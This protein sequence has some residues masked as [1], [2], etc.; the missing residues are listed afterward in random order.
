MIADSEN[1]PPYIIFSDSSLIEMAK[2]LPL[3]TVDMR[4]ISGMGDFKLEKY[5]Q[6]FLKIIKTYC[7][8][9]DLSTKIHLK[10]PKREKKPITQIVRRDSTY[11]ES[12]QFFLEGKSIQEIA[13]LRSLQVNT[14]MGHLSEFIQSG[15]VKL[16]R[17][18]HHEKIVIIKETVDKVG[19]S[20]IRQ[21][22]EALGSGYE[23]GEIK[24]VLAGL[25]P[26]LRIAVS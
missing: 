5:G 7:K 19:T 11:T 25:F 17:L 15:E 26:D 3:T 2:Y 22:K 24:A 6:D 16:E 18:V 21:I 20:S 12:L 23:Y 14:I 8:S 4:K 9:R 13:N 1:V 10:V